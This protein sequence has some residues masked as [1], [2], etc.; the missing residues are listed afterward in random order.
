MQK[1][2]GILSLSAAYHYQLTY[3]YQTTNN[4]ATVPS[5]VKVV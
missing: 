2:I 5:L 3:H 1:Y 4:K